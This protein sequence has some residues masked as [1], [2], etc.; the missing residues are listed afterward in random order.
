M[1][2]PTRNLKQE[3]RNGD[4]Q[5]RIEGLACSRGERRLFSGFDLALTAAEAVQIA[6]ANGRGK[7]TLLR[8][9]CG[10]QRPAAGNVSWNDRDVHDDAS[11]FVGA[12]LYLAHENALNPD[13]TPCENL[14]AL[15]RLHGDRS[16]RETIDEA[17]STLGVAALADRPCRHMSAGQKRRAA[18]ARLRLS[19]AP[20]WL[21]DEPAAG[22]DTEGRVRLGDCIAGHVAAG[23]RVLFTTHEPLR[24]PGIDV[25]TVDLPA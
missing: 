8:T 24:I 3:T 1:S 2:E 5:L 7:T 4:A 25:R 20:L 16:D 17:L 15:T 14:A 23:G 13:L 11:E 12:C 10:L 21:L 9:V 19:R 22:L 18:L 6:G